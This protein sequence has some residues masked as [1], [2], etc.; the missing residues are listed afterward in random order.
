MIHRSSHGAGSSER[1]FLAVTL[2]LLVVGM[3]ATAWVL[4]RGTI[5]YQHLAAVHTALA[6]ATSAVDDPVAWADDL[7]STADDVAAAHALTDDPVWTAAGALPWIG[8]HLR[9]MASVAS[10]GDRALDALDPLREVAS[11]LSSGSLRASDG[12]YDVA[13]LASWEPAARSAALALEVASSELS[14]AASADLRGSVADELARAREMVTRAH[15]EADAL[16]RTTR[17]LP[18]MLGADRARSYLV[19]FQNDA[20]WRSLGGIVGA[21]AQIDTDRG[22]VRLTAQASSTEFRG[23]GAAP[24]AELPD[25]LRAL[26]DDRPARFVQNVTQVPDFSVGAPLAREM[27]RRQHGTEVDGVIAVDPVA[28][29]YLLRATGPVTLPSGDVLT[30]ENAVPLL[31]DEVYRR[32]PDPTHQDAFFQSAS[33]AVFEAVA[34]GRVELRALADALDRAGRERRILVWNA[35]PAEQAMLDGTTLQGA[36]P[37]VDGGRTVFGVYVN[38]GTGSKMDYYMRLGVAASWCSPSS[39]A[40]RVTLR[41]EAPDPATLPDYVTGGGRYGV[42]VGHTLTGVYVYLPPGAS[43]T[44][45]RAT[46]EGAASGF[47]GGRDRGRDVLKWSV[48]LAPGQSATLDLRVATPATDILETLTTPTIH[49][50]DTPVGGAICANE[51]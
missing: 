15:D 1:A 30:S 39:A 7:A 4:V 36:L 33:S 45:Q 49:A 22:R 48:R 40:L 14:A 47:A 35:D 12:G 20:E 31:L 11:A 46:G 42:P 38:D 5:A 6:E 17:L 2:L 21:V 19:V 9:A 3:L 13:R 32:Y 43:V 26:F 18:D 8:P 25:G 41:N 10:A 27:W 51:G 37:A 34:G 50:V 44:H 28:L 16:H 29:S 24:V 23:A